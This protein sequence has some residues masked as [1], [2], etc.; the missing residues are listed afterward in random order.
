M[1]YL[2]TLS[3]GQPEPA[4]GRLVSAA[5]AR[6]SQASLYVGRQAVQLHGG[7]GFSDELAVGHYLKRLIMIDMAY[8]NG[9]HHRRRFAELS[10]LAGPGGL[11]DGLPRPPQTARA[12]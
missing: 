4:R 3:L 9:D 10:R 2:A 5:K 6:V 8:G 12:S 1:T 7:V 11:A